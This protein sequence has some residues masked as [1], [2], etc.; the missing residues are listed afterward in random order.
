MARQTENRSVRVKVSV[1]PSDHGLLLEKAEASGKSL[2]DFLRDAG[3]AR[4]ASISTERIIDGL[5]V[6]ELVLKQLNALSRECEEGCL[7]YLLILLRLRQIEKQI[8]MFAPVP[9]RKVAEEC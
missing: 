1:T 5:F 2:S 9:E 7:D 6:L 3:L 4:R 8:M